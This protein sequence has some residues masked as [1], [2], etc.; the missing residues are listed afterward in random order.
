MAFH[1]VMART[2][3]CRLR[4]FCNTTEKAPHLGKGYANTL[5]FYI[6][7]IATRQLNANFSSYIYATC[8]GSA[9]RVGGQFLAQYSN[10]AARSAIIDLNGAASQQR[11]SHRFCCRSLILSDDVRCCKWFYNAHYCS[12]ETNIRTMAC[13]VC[14]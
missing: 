14:R 4:A 11:T 8:R 5:H 13:D 1:A 6:F 3:R 12:V 7:L 2:R 9:T 10:I